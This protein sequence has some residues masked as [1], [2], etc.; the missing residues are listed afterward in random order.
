MT[1]W[2]EMTA[3]ERKEIVAYISGMTK[4]ECCQNG[5][6][7]QIVVWPDLDFDVALSSNDLTAYFAYGSD[8][9][10][11]PLLRL[12]RPMSHAEVRHALEA[13]TAERAVA[14]F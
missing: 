3:A 8:E 13:A 9:R 2:D 5:Y 14:G 6:G 7:P 12:C 4:T 1:S 10:V 11:S